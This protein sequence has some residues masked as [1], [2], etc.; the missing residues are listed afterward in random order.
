MPVEARPITPRLS[1]M[2]RVEIDGLD[3]AL[4]Q[5]VQIPNRVLET[6]EHASG[7]DIYNRGYAAGARVEDLVLEKI[8][9][10]DE[11]DTWGYD[12]L[13]TAANMAEN[14]LGLA[15]QYKKQVSVYHLDVNGDILQEWHFEG[16]FVKQVALN[17][18]NA[19][20]KTD[21]VVET[22]TIHVDRQ[23]DSL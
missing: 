11:D 4:V 8:K 3:S 23:I 16:C 5:S 1:F 13:R 10:A 12:W 20:N 7:G 18:N 6:V 21:K 9:P 19:L 15:S 17:Q 14:T 2:Y 22:V